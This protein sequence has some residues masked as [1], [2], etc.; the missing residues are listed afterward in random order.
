MSVHSSI[1]TAIFL[2]AAAV[3]STTA[4]AQV[5]V[6]SAILSPPK[7][8]DL[9][10]IFDKA[11][12]E[13]AGAKPKSKTGA[14]RPAAAPAKPRVLPDTFS[15]ETEDPMSILD[16]NPDVLTRFSAALA[17][18][19]ARRSQG[20]KLT[21][22]KYDEVGAAAGGF[23]PRQYFVLKARVRPFC[24]AIAAGKAPS[25]NLTL[26]YMPTEAMAIR[27]RCSTLLPALKLNL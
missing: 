25:D 14:S 1:L 24:E 7:I 18:E 23:T 13:P 2:V 10:S 27:P 22:L 20:G 4:R 6:E 12:K 11:G 17:V 26:S 16:I 21:R 9:G 19:T 3:V 8:R 5:I 15:G